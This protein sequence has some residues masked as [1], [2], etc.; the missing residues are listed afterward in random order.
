V[1][2]SRDPGLTALEAATQQVTFA[3][4]TSIVDQLAAFLPTVG[5]SGDDAGSIARRTGLSLSRALR[6]GDIT[7]FPGFVPG[8]TPGGLNLTFQQRERFEARTAR[9]PSGLG[10][11]DP[12]TG[13][14][15]TEAINSLQT[16]LSRFNAPNLGSGA[17]ARV[18]EL[19]SQITELG[20]TPVVP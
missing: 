16:E 9:R 8:V 17:Q 18:A 4:G 10:M 5:F 2:F 7:Q 14:A 19:S 3:P 6:R 20:G 13:Q 1:A 11:V 12:V 15:N